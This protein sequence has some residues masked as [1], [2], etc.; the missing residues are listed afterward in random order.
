MI[1]KKQTLQNYLNEREVET[2][3]SDDFR[4]RFDELSN[5]CHLFII[6]LSMFKKSELNL[7]SGIDIGIA[8]ALA[9]YAIIRMD[10]ENAK[11]KSELE[12]EL[13]YLIICHNEHEIANIS[14]TILRSLEKFRS[15]LKL[16]YEND[17][18]SQ[19][20]GPRLKLFQAVKE[21]YDEF[22]KESENIKKIIMED[23][24]WPIWTI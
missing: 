21:E 8:K 14:I 9:H 1:T 18:V 7:K 23:R 22:K 4:M 15:E 24:K 13:T 5:L 12:A 20:R 2:H 6:D 10:P 19:L 17:N 3:S 16:E 11:L